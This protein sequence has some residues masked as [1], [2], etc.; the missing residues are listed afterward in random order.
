MVHTV[1]LDDKHINIKKLLKEIQ[2]QKQG[3]RFGNSSDNS[4]APEGY[5]SSEDFWNEADKRI[6]NV[7]KQYGVL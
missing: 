6:I 2:S 3:V 4:I 1:F 5:M 7:C